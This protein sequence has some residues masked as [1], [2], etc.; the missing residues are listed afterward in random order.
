MFPEYLY[1]FLVSLRFFLIN[2]DQS[3]F[4]ISHQLIPKPVGNKIE[5][6]AHDFHII[7]SIQYNDILILE[8]II[9]NCYYTGMV[10]VRIIILSTHSGP[11]MV[12]QNRDNTQILSFRNYSEPMIG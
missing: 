7:R 8:P 6:D 10:S 1:V 9:K 12:H 5:I 3:A 11:Q 4:V 2:S